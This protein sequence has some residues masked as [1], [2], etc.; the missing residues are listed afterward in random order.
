MLNDKN[1]LSRICG[2]WYNGE[3]GSGPFYECTWLW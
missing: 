3:D 2:Y 1:L